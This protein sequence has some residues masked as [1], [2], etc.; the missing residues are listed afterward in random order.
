[1]KL[2]LDFRNGNAFPIAKFQ[3][4][5]VKIVPSEDESNFFIVKFFTEFFFK[6]NSRPLSTILSSLMC[7]RICS[8]HAT[9]KVK[10]FKRFIEI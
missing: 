5:T 8:W 7:P 1:V 9:S 2:E 10:G 3:N 4:F 6:I